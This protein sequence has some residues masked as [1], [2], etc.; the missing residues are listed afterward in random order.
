MF[1]SSLSDHDAHLAEA[2]SENRE[3]PVAISMLPGT[4]K[5]VLARQVDILGRVE[6]SPLLFFDATTHPLGNPSL[7]VR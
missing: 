1:G 7:A 3:R 6:A 5:E 4:R 2:L